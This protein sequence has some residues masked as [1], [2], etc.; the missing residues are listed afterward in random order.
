MKS[1]IIQLI[2]KNILIEMVRVMEISKTNIRELNKE[3]VIIFKTLLNKINEVYQSKSFNKDQL[4]ETLLIDEDVYNYYKS[5]EQGL[6]SIERRSIESIPNSFIIFRL[7]EKIYSEDYQIKKEAYNDYKKIIDSGLEGIHFELRKRLIYNY[8]NTI[9][10]LENINKYRK[11]DFKKVE[12]IFLDIGLLKYNNNLYEPLSNFD[13][14]DPSD[15]RMNLYETMLYTIENVKSLLRLPPDP[16][17]L[18]SIHE[19]VKNGLKTL[20]EYHEE[21]IDN[22]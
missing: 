22:Y 10:I 5:S 20:D 15:S 9:I 7:D 18:D 17:E 8:A 12:T 21:N 3:K 1:C 11:K 2:K 6:T 14:N 4:E 13:M 19:I 16:S